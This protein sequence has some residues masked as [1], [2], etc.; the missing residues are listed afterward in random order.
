LKRSAAAG[1]DGV[2]WSEY[3]EGLDERIGKLWA[4]VHCGRY[5]A[6][7][8]RRAYIPKA[9]G[10]RPPGVAALQDKIVQQ[11][12]V[13]VLTPIHV[14]NVLGSSYGFR[15]GRNRHQAL[16]A[17]VVGMHTKRVNWVLDADINTFAQTGISLAF[18]DPFMQGLRHAA[19]LGR[20]GAHREGY[21]PRC[22]CT[23]RTARSRTSGENFVDLLMAPS[24]Q[25][26][27]PLQNPGRFPA[28]ALHCLLDAP[29]LV[30]PRCT[31]ST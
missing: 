3:E 16:D 1:V 2:K 19:D 11:A 12:V 13:T 26:L 27:E 8:S 10:Q 31:A 5:R 9:D 6:L 28:T 24:S 20:Y 25:K 17:L 14:A 18:L 21:S 4:A 15:P 29:Y 23:M 22:S 7:P 30:L